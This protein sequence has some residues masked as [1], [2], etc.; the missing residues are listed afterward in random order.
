MTRERSSLEPRCLRRSGGVDRAAPFNP[1][2]SHCTAASSSPTDS[3]D[4]SHRSPSHSTLARY[5]RRRAPLRSRDCDSARQP[6]LSRSI[7]PIAGP[8][9]ARAELR[10][11]RAG[12]GQGAVRSRSR[13]GGTE[14]GGALAGSHDASTAAERSEAR[15]A[16]SER[17]RARRGVLGVRGGECVVRE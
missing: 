13:Q 17:P 11:L 10:A 12:G 1:T 9:A 15:R 6:V 4:G 2:H 5:R 3:L 8:R 16:A 7:R 14:R